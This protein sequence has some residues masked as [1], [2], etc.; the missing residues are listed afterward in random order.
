MTVTQASQ[1]IAFS[2]IDADM[3]FN[4]RTQ[5][6]EQGIKDLADS[7]EAQGLETPLKVRKNG[8]TK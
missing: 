1:T 8:G 6:D 2:K 7:I 4:V 5:Y 3:L